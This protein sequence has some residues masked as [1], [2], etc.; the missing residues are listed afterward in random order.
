MPAYFLQSED[1][2]IEGNS[3]FQ[4]RNAITGVEKLLYHSKKWHGPENF[5]PAM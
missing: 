1:V 4:V 3:L 2:L 5:Q